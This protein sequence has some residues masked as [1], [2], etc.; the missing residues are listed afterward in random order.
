MLSYSTFISMAVEVTRGEL[1]PDPYNF[2]YLPAGTWFK[3]LGSGVG[4]DENRKLLIHSETG[5][6]GFI[7]DG[8][9]WNEYDIRRFR[10][11]GRVAIFQKN[12][13]HVVGIDEGR[14]FKGV[15]GFSRGESAVVVANSTEP[16]GSNTEVTI[17]FDLLEKL[18][19]KDGKLVIPL[20]NLT[21]EKLPST[22]RIP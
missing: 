5:A 22:A 20:T 8:Q 19:D 18:K 13:D 1:F 15:I 9:Y 12:H 7:S 14:Q 6:V 16:G 21:L 17:R 10:Q 4:D 11:N 3:T 2:G